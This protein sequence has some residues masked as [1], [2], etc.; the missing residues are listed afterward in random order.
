MSETISLIVIGPG[1]DNQVAAQL[2]YLGDSACHEPDMVAVNDDQ[3]SY[4]IQCKFILTSEMQDR[5]MSPPHLRISGESLLGVPSFLYDLKLSPQNVVVAPNQEYVFSVKNAVGSIVYKLYSEGDTAEA[6]EWV[7][8]GEEEKPVFDPATGYFNVP[9][10]SGNY[11]LAIK[12]EAENEAIATIHVLTNLKASFERSGTSVE[13]SVSLSVQDG[14]PP[15]SYHI[16]S[17][18]AELKE[19]AAGAVVTPLAVGDLQVRV[20]DAT[21]NSKV[22][23]LEVFSAFKIVAPNDVKSLTYF[24]VGASGGKPPYSYHVRDGKVSVHEKSGLAIA[25]SQSLSFSSYFKKSMVTVAVRDSLGQ[26]RE[27]DIAVMGNEVFRGHLD[28]GVIINTSSSE[29]LFAGKQFAHL[30][31]IPQDNLIYIDVP[32]TEVISPE[33][34]YH[35]RS[36]VEDRIRSKGLEKRLNYLVTTKGVPLKVQYEEGLD[37]F[38]VFS[39]NTRSASVDSELALILGPYSESIGK[40]SIVQNPY[41]RKLGPFSR[42]IYGVFLV[43]RLDAYDIDVYLKQLNLISERTWVKKEK[44]FF[45]FDQDP[46]WNLFAALLNIRLLEAAGITSNLGFPTT[47]D[48]TTTYLRNQR[49]VLGYASWGSNDHSSTNNHQIEYQWVPGSIANT[50]VSTSGRTFERGTG[51]GQSLIADLLAEGVSGAI[52]FVYEPYTSAMLDNKILFSS[53]VNGFNYA[54][55]AYK[56]SPTL[57]WMTVMIGDPK[58][59]IKTRE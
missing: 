42:S 48:Q 24:H 57:S 10:L 23:N 40:T 58:M 34:F 46:S 36:Q 55:S 52:G 18:D 44:S 21:G 41:Y 13:S 27:A 14:T 29:S 16:I 12:D 30:R 6:H 50:Y 53:Y 37:V 39:P 9:Q 3:F 19:V 7:V 35:L 59:Q 43:T 17:G 56:A 4:G 28:T 2:I 1:L 31:G 8:P 5:T 33:Q 45:V 15:Y 51:G 38:S 54:E 32:T 22:V 25:V 26:I 47:L 11:V 20:Y 49:N